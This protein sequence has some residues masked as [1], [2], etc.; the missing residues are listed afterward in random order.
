VL[1]DHNNELT[2]DE[3]LASG[4]WCG[5]TIYPDTKMDEH[6]LVRIVEQHGIERVIINSAADWG[7]SDPL[8]VPKT[9]AALQAAGF[10]EVEIQRLVWD[11]PV[12]FFGQSGRLELESGAAAPDPSATFA[13]NSI[14]RGARAQ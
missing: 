12:A 1:I 4:C 3:V 13:G 8:K 2:Y 9:V 7:R 5:F 11:N 6:R 10:A 14:L